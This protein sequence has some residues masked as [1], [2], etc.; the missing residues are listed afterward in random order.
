MVVVVLAVTVVDDPLIW[1]LWAIRWVVFAANLGALLLIERSRLVTAMRLLVVGHAF[2]GIG[3]T[4][5]LPE[6]APLVML[7]LF[8]SLEMV[9]LLPRR[10]RAPHVWIVVVTAAVTALVAVRT[11]TSLADSVP[12]WLL[13]A[14]FLGHL[15]GTASVA[16]GFAR[17][18][19]A[20]LVRQDVAARELAVQLEEVTAHERRR[21]ETALSEGVMSDLERLDDLLRE[22]DD[23]LAAGALDEAAAQAA[24]GADLAQR[25][26]AELRDVAHGIFPDSLRRYGLGTAI[27]S[28]AARTGTRWRLDIDLEPGERFPPDVEAAAFAWVNDVTAPTPTTNGTHPTQDT[29]AMNGTGD[30]PGVLAVTR[31][32]DDLRVVAT[33][34][35]AALSIPTR[36]RVAALDGWWRWDATSAEMTLP[37]ADTPDTPDAVGVL[38]DDADADTGGAA[39]PA[40]SSPSRPAPLADVRVIEQFLRSGRALTLAGLGAASALALLTRSVAVTA[41]AI[42]VVGTALLVG[43][44]RLALRRRR[45]GASLLLVCLQTC[46]SALVVTALVPVLAP[47]T[48]LITTLPMLLALPFLSSRLLTVVTVTQ[49]SVLGVVGVIGMLAEGLVDDDVPRWLITVGVPIAAAAVTGLVAATM[50]VTTDEAQ[51]RVS[52]NRAALRTLVARSD[53]ERRRIERDLHDG[54]QQHVVAASMQCRSLSKLAATDPRRARFVLAQLRQQLREARSDVIALVA[55]A[56]PEVLA[57]ARLATA[58]RRSAAMCALPTTVDVRD[59]SEIPAHVAVAVYY[60]I[61]EALQ[62]AAKHAGPDATV[63]VRMSVDGANVHFEVRDDGRGFTNAD[64]EVRDDGD[65]PAPGHGIE[66]LRQRMAAVGGAVRLTSDG[67][68]TGAMLVGVAPLSPTA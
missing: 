15:V 64:L 62:N 49:T 39:P 18:T 34:T 68:G 10:A 12:A 29:H 16:T 58:V 38:G 6:Y 37:T 66:S 54:A 67:P 1:A 32:G 35:P 4:L 47:V 56:F 44:A 57:D 23:H 36:N 61:H 7:V 53:A 17:G 59:D 25:A 40:A 13:V 46:L 30:E 60:C 9:I 33:G 19:Y 20:E 48:A 3:S 55:G 24:S 52:R 50:L 65:D 5:V 11:E 41:L 31:S 27:T 2:G 21:I 63:S 42:S 45:L 26:L 28:M 8:A 22:T 51:R 14:V 43:A